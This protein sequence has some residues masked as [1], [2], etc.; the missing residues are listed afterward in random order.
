M[1]SWHGCKSAR[2]VDKIG[3]SDASRQYLSLDFLMGEKGCREYFKNIFSLSSLEEVDQ[4]HGL[5]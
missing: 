1:P 4:V 3:L 5:V 2:K